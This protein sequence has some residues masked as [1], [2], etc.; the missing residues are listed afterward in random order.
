[1]FLSSVN[2]W[3]QS[4]LNSFCISLTTYEVWLGK[5][6][7]SLT[8]LL[9]NIKEEDFCLKLQEILIAVKNPTNV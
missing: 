5:S 7:I 4:I 8:R 3:E 6:F 9:S 2:A 1:M